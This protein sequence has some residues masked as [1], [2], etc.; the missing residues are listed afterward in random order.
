MSVIVVAAVTVH[1]SWISHVTKKGEIV[2]YYAECGE[3]FAA[4]S[5]I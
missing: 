5:S 2:Q 3:F 4:W 1:Q